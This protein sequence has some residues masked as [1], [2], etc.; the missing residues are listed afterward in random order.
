MQ[1]DAPP[2][3]PQRGGQG[4]ARK[5]PELGDA[6]VVRHVVVY[7]ASQSS[8]YGRGIFVSLFLCIPLHTTLK[9]A[10]LGALVMIP[11]LPEAYR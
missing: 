11:E 6:G 1:V 3:I 7:T 10:F 8:P 2:G 5:R 4:T 9:G